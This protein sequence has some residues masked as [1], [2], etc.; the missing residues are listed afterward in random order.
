MT[1]DRKP[2]RS[3][4]MGSMQC[5]PGLASQ[6]SNLSAPI[7]ELSSIMFWCSEKFLDERAFRVRLLHVNPLAIALGIA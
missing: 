6:C 5:W 2:V 3:I 4:N 7:F 1:A